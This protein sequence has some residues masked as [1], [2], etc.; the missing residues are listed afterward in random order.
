MVAASNNVAP[1]LAMWAPPQQQRKP[2]P[3]A[4]TCPLVFPFQ[5]LSTADL[6]FR[7]QV[8]KALQ[9]KQG[10]ENGPLVF[11]L[12]PHNAALVPAV[13]EQIQGLQNGT[14]FQPTEIRPKR[15]TFL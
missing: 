12:W 10:V 5:S 8:I 3:L 6:S 9:S 15:F 14:V 11:L 1:S 2:L 4:C 7:G 13:M